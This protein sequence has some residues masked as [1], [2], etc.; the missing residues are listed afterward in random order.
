M[1]F[2]ICLTSLLALWEGSP[3]ETHSTNTL[4]LPFKEVTLQYIV[5][6]V[7]IKKSEHGKEAVKKRF[8]TIQSENVMGDVTFV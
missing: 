4:R 5:T 3:Q 7:Y 6:I 2:Y 8:H 1:S